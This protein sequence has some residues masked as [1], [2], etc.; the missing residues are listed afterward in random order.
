[1]S[2]FYH[3]KSWSRKRQYILRRDSY[4]CQ[5]CKR[6]G[7]TTE[8]K[9]VHHIFPLDTNPEYKLLN[10]NLISV[11]HPC[12]NSYHNRFNNAELTAIGLQLKRRKEPDIL[13]AKR[14]LDNRFNLSA[15]HP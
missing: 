7:K 11:C 9:V 6:H 4:L 5:E 1:M 12:H 8:A 3:S 13:Y 14:Q 2:K 10:E 15:R